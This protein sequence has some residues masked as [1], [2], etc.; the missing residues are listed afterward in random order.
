MTNAQVFPL[1]QYFRKDFSFFIVFN[2][3]RLMCKR[4]YFVKNNL[5]RAKNVNFFGNRSVIGGKGWNYDESNLKT[6]L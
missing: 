3:K 6:A 1:F 4:E 2:S 5:Y